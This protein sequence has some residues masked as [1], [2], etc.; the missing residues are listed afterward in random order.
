[1]VAASSPPCTTFHTA[2]SK[3]SRLSAL[4][5]HRRRRLTTLAQHV[6]R[7]P[8][9]SSTTDPGEPAASAL[10]QTPPIEMCDRDKFLLDVNGDDSGIACCCS[11]GVVSGVLTC[12]FAR[13]SL[14]TGFLVVE[15]FLTT[16]EVSA[17]NASFDANWNRR[18]KGAANARGKRRGF[19]QF[20][21]MLSWPPS[22]SQPFRDLLAH[23]KLVVSVAREWPL[24][25]ISMP[26]AEWLIR[27]TLP[28]SALP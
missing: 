2:R 13:M 18:V 19:D 21:G 11:L 27:P 5:L 8:T 4:A 20:H 23:P 25:L 12:A 9:V 14:C 1:M 16:E 7:A 10:L 28:G 26:R 22:H 24:I 17:L 15:E 3:N 6:I